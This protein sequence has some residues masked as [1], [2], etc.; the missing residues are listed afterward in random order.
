MQE[1][2]PEPIIAKLVDASVCAT[3]A[4]AVVTFDARGVSGHVNHVATHRGVLTWLQGHGGGV[5]CWLLVRASQT[6][7]LLCCAHSI[8]AGERLAGPQVHGSA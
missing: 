4:K 1:R 3:R 2:W 7:M 5:A 6:V 8:V